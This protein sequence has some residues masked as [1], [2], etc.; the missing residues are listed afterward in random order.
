RRAPTCAACGSVTS[1]A[2]RR[3]IGGVTGCYALMQSANARRL[4]QGSR[5]YRATPLF[6]HPTRAREILDTQGQSIDSADHGVVVSL[7]GGR[8]TREAPSRWMTSSP[9]LL[10]PTWIARNPL[11]RRRDRGGR[12]TRSRWRSLRS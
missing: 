1:A 10:A 8:G 3:E 4:K 2:D 9:R 12:L 5:P 6:L 7:T 11:T